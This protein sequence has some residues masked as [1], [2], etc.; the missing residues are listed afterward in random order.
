VKQGAVITFSD[1]TEQKEAE[2]SLR[3]AKEEAEN[4][5]QAKSEFLSRMSHELRTPMNSILGFGQLLARHETSADKLRNIDHIMRA[6]KHLL[7]LINEV[8][9]LAR[10]EAN[11]MQLS[12]EPVEVDAVIREAISLVRPLAESS[13]CVLI[14]TRAEGD[15]FHVRADRQRLTQVLLNL[16]SNA[17]KYNR[18]GGSVTVWCEPTVRGEG[19]SCL[20]IHVRDTGH[21]IPAGKLDELFVPFSRLGAEQGNIEGTGLGLALSQRLVE[22]MGGQLF[23]ESVV[24]EGSTFSVELPRT[25]SPLALWASSTTVAAGSPPPELPAATLLYIE[26][27]LANFSLI[28]SILEAYPQINLLAAL[29][30]RRGLELAGE[31]LPDLILLDL[32]LPDMP[33]DDVL[34]ELRSDAS[35]RD[36]PVI[37]ISA[38]ATPSRIQRLRAAGADD[39]ITKPLDVD[40]FLAAVDRVLGPTKK[41]AESDQVERG[42]DQLPG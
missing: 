29:Q 28:E 1:I 13:G 33:G 17:I 41:S 22:A 8:L 23:V 21:G 25:E 34:R 10:I 27:N 39:Y 4:A 18:S 20:R 2:R 37:V 26:D 9:E 24:G 40:G 35:T 14:E 32:H 5:N 38:D 19:E 3:R 7:R 12:I 42:R 6:G 30:G 16:L 15:A 31:H 36:I 11:R